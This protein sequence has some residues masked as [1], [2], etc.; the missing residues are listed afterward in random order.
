[1]SI[2][3]SVWNAHAAW[4]HRK[5]GRQIWQWSGGLHVLENTC[6][7]GYVCWSGPSMKPKAL[8]R[9]HRAVKV[10][11]LTSGYF[12]PVLPARV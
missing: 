9:G 8:V 1:M 5:V 10:E 2:Y 3:I 6:L 7:P 11:V 12:L 4:C